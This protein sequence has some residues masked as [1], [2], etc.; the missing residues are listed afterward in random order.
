MHKQIRL[1]MLI[2]AKYIICIITKINYTSRQ[3]LN[4]PHGSKNHFRHSIN[5][6]KL[7]KLLSPAECL[8]EREQELSN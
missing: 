2:S 6:E 1:Q 3:F 8:G 4:Y 7:I 5:G